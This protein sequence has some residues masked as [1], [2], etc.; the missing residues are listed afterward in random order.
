M[1]VKIPAELHSKLVLYLGSRRYIDVVELVPLLTSLTSDDQGGYAIE[2][3][4][5][6]RIVDYFQYQCV[7]ADVAQFI[8]TI[9]Q[10][11][12]T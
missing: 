6:Q 1:K 8:S 7:Y 4:D 12:G 10:L 11:E 2:V 9:A 3:A 5:L